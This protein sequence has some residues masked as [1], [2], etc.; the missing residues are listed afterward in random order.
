MPYGTL[1]ACLLLLGKSVACKM[2]RPEQG[3][4]EGGRGWCGTWLGGTCFLSVSRVDLLVEVDL[5][6]APAM[7]CG[8][9]GCVGTLCLLATCRCARCILGRPDERALSSGVRGPCG[10]EV[11]EEGGCVD[12]SLVEANFSLTS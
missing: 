8:A 6:D 7:T 11:E 2:P 9:K 5:V 4:E 10:V 12:C 1:Q 3:Q